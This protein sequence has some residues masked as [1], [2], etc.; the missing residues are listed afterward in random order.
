VFLRLMLCSVTVVAGRSRVGAPISSLI[1]ELLSN[2]GEE[3]LH[4][5]VI[6]DPYTPFIRALLEAT[7]GLCRSPAVSATD[8]PSRVTSGCR[9][10]AASRAWPNDA[11]HAVH[12]HHR[13]APPRPARRGQ[14]HGVGGHG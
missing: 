5:F 3:Y 11:L 4:L 14:R 7:D 2:D 8:R 6:E 12:A 10:R 13:P 1:G 9:R